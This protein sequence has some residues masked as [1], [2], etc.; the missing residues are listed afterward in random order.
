MQPA[1]HALP[2]AAQVAGHHLDG[3]GVWSVALHGRTVGPV[4]PG[5]I[6]LVGARAGRIRHLEVVQPT[7]EDVFISL[8][9]RQL[10]D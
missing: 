9:G 5:L 1:L 10:R 8:T 2:T 3:D 6:E 7:L 4:L